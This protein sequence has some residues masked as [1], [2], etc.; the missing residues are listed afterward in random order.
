VTQPSNKE[1]SAGSTRRQFLV[2]S[3][4]LAGTAT[5]AGL[6]LERSVHAAG[7]DVVKIGLIGCGGRGSGAVVSALSVNPAARLTAM[8]DAF[9]DRMVNARKQIE[10]R[11]GDRADVDD[12]HLFDGFD[13]HQRLLESG[14]DVAIL[15]EPPHFR[16]MHIEACVDAGVHV[17]AEKPMAVDAPGVRR[18]L[19]AGEKARQKNVS[20]VSGFETRYSAAA[21]ETVGRVH[22]G[23]IGDIVSMQMT[24]NTGPLWHRGHEPEWTE[25]QFQMR[26][27]YYFTWLSGDH[28]VEQHVHLADFTAWLMK[29]EP[30][31]HA[32]GYGGRQ[33]RVEPKYGDIFDHHA[34]VYEYANG[35]RVYALCRQQANCYREVS[36]LV[37]GT[38]G[39]LHPGTGGWGHYI[40]EGDTNWT[41]PKDEGHPELNTFRE[42][43]AGIQSGKPI[44]DS[45]SMGNSTM[46][47]I[48]G[49]MATHSGQKITWD[50]A[51]N[52]T[53]DLSPKS[54]AWD[55]DPPVLP[56][57]D[58]HY[59]QPMPGVTKVL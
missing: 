44:N 12:D 9:R 36:K 39:Q 46:L 25:M 14:V 2:R 7:S 38:K 29:D 18:V 34:V 37:M 20:F 22:E 10:K 50:E 21:R 43:F 53:L 41:A 42:M 45:H 55:A 33:V 3:A 1:K 54:Y 31:L 8:S 49:R 16:P 19:A 40:I 17:F 51:F 11:A 56:G 6:A 47:A 24:Y 35:T 58:G 32:W 5:T 28:N 23:A 59:P 15:A 27:W 48:L 13:G 57:P 4:V 26:N 30:P 52:S